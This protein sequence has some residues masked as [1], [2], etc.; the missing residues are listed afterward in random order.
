MRLQCDAVVQQHRPVHLQH[1][2]GRE[3]HEHP[4]RFGELPRL[5]QRLSSSVLLAM[6]SGGT[7][8]HVALSCQS[9]SCGS[10]GVPASGCC[11][12][13]SGVLRCQERT[14]RGGGWQRG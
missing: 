7:S 13:R 9:C 3:P 4:L 8:S 6:L 11:I 1:A 14:L 12:L 5:F 10:C 2:A